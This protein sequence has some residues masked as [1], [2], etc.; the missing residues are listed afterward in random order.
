M[1]DQRL[2]KLPGVRVI[3]IISALLTLIQAGAIIAQAHFLTK[4]LVLSWRMQSLNSLTT[5]TILFAC[6]FLL[7]QLCVWLKNIILDKYADKT[8]GALRDQLLD[9]VYVTGAS[10]VAQSGTGKLV[11]VALDGINNVYNYFNLIFAKIIDMAIIPW[12]ILIYIYFNSG[13]SGLILTLVFPIVIIFMIILGFAAQDKAD[14]QYAGFLRLSNHFVDSLR[15]LSTLKFLGLS[16]KYETNVYN[17][18][19][20]YRRSTM[21]VLKIAILST[22]ALDWFTTLSIAL[23]ALFLGLGLINGSIPL[24]PALV[25]LILAPE[26]F[27]P[28]RDFGNDYH[29]TLDGK[30]ALTDILDIVAQPSVTNRQ[31]VP[32]TF[33]WDENSKLVANH[34]NLQYS[35]DENEAIDLT[36]IAFT[37]KGYQKVG[38]IGMSGSGKTTLLNALGGFLTPLKSEDP[39]A[40][41]FSLNGQDLPHLS[42]ANWQQQFAFIPQF[43]YLFADTIAANIAFYQPK[44]SAAQ[45]AAAASQAGLDDFLAT[46]KDGLNTLVGE[47][48]RGIS[49]GQAQRIALARAFLDQDRHVL[50]FDEP[51]AHLDIETEYALKETMMPL[52]KNHLV[53]FA[54]HRLHWLKEMDYILVMKDGQLVQQGTLDELSATPGEFTALTQHMQ[55]RVSLS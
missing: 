2:F 8:S 22:F 37:L 29:A 52:F 34:F 27:L 9:K 54:T 26:F 49:G 21:D 39:K 38:I 6:A 25:S 14:K 5:D 12:L 4:V 40:A 33:K 3:L 46:L 17:V 53:L 19:E 45:I 10:Q 7:R 30:N 20:D 36:D 15:G 35:P 24:F 43:P 11:T 48:G 31:L 1:I 16:E 47:G 55:K 42:Q 50:M 23:L 51:T 41:N 44:A 13:R 32:D 28:I 18:S